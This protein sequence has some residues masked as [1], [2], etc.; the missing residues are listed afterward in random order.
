[1]RPVFYLNSDVQYTGAGDGSKDNPLQLMEPTQDFGDYLVKNPSAGLSTTVYGGMYRYSGNDQT[2]ADGTIVGTDKVNN[3]VELGDVLYRIIGV[4]SE[5]NETLGLEKGMVKVIKAETIGNQQ[6]WIDNKTDIEWE[7][8]LIYQRLNDLDDD[9]TNN[10]LSNINIIPSVFVNSIASVKWN[11]GDL[12]TETAT[13]ESVLLSEKTN[14]TNEKSKIG[15]MYAS[16]YYYAADI[17][18]AT[19]CSGNT[20]CLNWLTDIDNITWTMTRYGELS[21]DSYRLW[22]VFTDGSLSTHSMTNKRALHPVF[23]LSKDVQYTIKGNG[24]K[25]NPFQIRPSK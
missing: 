13:A 12:K 4:V 14:Q 3:Y 8:S 16:D 22:R 7:R 10:V 17:S 21:S 24:T 6:W 15:L 23:Y 25:A 18:G 19:N 9:E 1:M 2:S 20:L 5:D 11:V